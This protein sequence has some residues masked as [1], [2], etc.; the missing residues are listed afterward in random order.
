M[1]ITINTDAS[2][3]RHTKRGSWAFWISSDV[4]RFKKSGVL[5]EKC[6]G[7]IQ[8]EIMAVVNALHYCRTH[9]KLKVATKII[10]NTDCK[11][12]INIAENPNGLK[13][14]SQKEL[15]SLRGWIQKYIG[16]FRGRKCEVEFRWVKGH[17]DG[18]SARSYVNNYIDKEARKKLRNE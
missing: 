12:A 18:E 16:K 14:N 2:W 4:G 13:K 9:K 7:N 15:R 3:C 11:T 17:S 6:N 8:A 5:K 1:L 10:V